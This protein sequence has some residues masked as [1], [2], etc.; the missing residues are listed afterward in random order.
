MA[1]SG[2][3]AGDSSREGLA[4]VVDT[5]K[6]PFCTEYI[7]LMF[8]SAGSAFYVLPLGGAFGF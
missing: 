8:V 1:G 7:F 2:N 4:T 5:P 6:K 3:V